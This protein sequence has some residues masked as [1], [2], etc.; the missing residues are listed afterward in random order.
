MGKERDDQSVKQSI[1]FPVILYHT[2]PQLIEMPSLAL[3]PVAPVRLSLSEPA[4][5]TKCNLADS[6]SSSD[7]ASPDPLPLAW[8]SS[9]SPL[10][11]CCCVSIDECYKKRKEKKFR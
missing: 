9:L 2:R 7:P 3:S 10:P 4:R 6:V 8:P 11:F 1:G 5:S